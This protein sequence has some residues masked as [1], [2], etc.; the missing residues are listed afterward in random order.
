MRCRAPGS[1]HRSHR[2]RVPVSTE[3]L[4]GP[5]ARRGDYLSLKFQSREKSSLKKPAHKAHPQGQAPGNAQQGFP[6]A[7]FARPLRWRC[8]LRK[9]EKRPEAGGHPRP[10]PTR[11]QGAKPQGE[12]TRH[13]R[14]ESGVLAP[15]PIVS[16]SRIRHPPGPVTRPDPITSPWSR[17][18]GREGPVPSLTSS[19]LNVGIIFHDRLH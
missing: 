18:A 5:H 1:D 9:R 16:A 14:P 3:T 17:R 2:G 12:I 19:G 4:E 15:L 11:V 13:P 7:P 8:L 6:S 10:A